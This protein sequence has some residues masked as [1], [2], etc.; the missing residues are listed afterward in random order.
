MLICEA[1]RTHARLEFEYRGYHR[2]VEPY[3]H[4]VAAT[5]NDVLRAVQVGG[6]SKSGGLGFGKLWLVSEL[7]G[8]RISPTTFEPDDPAYNP[9]DRGMIQIHCRV[10]SARAR[11]G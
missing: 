1:I 3:C 11:H 6:T 5:G 7:I 8:L 4:G 2:I 10:L 9:D